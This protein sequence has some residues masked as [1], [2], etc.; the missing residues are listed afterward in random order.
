MSSMIKTVVFWLVILISAMLLWQVVKNA[1]RN[2]QQVSEVSYSQFLS[3]VDTGRVA[4]V[5]IA[6]TTLDGSYRDGGAFRVIVPASQEQMLEAL[7]QKQV[8]VWY[9]D[10]PDQSLANW[11]MNLA[12]LALLAALWFFMIR[13]MRSRSNAK[14]GAVAANSGAP[15]LGK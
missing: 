1:N 8:E 3:D 12:P 2:T 5:T 15:W 13:Q 9:A 14:A 4:K 11:L 10:K 7:R 6:K